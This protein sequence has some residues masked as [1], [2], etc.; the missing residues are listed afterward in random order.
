MQS[1]QLGES[2]LQFTVMGLGTWAIG[3]PD[4]QWGWGPQDDRDSIETIQRALDLGIN[5]IDTA[6]VY[7]LGHSE[8]IVGRAV[9]A[10]RDKVYIATKCA[11]RWK[12]KGKIYFSLEKTSIR[13]ECEASLKRLDIE[14]IDLYQIHWPID[15]NHLEEGWEEIA[16]LIQEGKVRYAGVSNFSIEQIKRCQAIHPVVSLQPPYS[17][18]QRDIEKELLPFCGANRIGVVPYGTMRNGLLCGNW[19]KE[20][21]ESLPKNDWRK[22]APDFK[23]PQLESNLNKIDRLR[24]IAEA[25]G[26]SMAHLAI[27]WVMRRPEVT[28]PIIGARRPTQIEETIRAADLK[29]DEKDLQ[30]IERILGGEG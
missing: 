21:S 11:Q 10:R 20:R 1:Q 14:T 7:G 12:A 22:Y 3:G 9:K 23:S 15:D 5:W 27:A 19:S 24:P 8:E 13:E 17:M 4:W 29:L 28:A 18:L 16:R 26:V 6:A 25:Y 2:D 30:K